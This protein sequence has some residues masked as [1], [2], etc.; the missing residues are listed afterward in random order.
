MSPASSAS[1]TEAIT[2]LLTHVITNKKD[3]VSKQMMKNIKTF[4]GTKRTECIN[5]PQPD[6]SNSQVLQL[7]IYRASLPRYG[8]INATCSL[9]TV[10]NVYRLRNQGCDT[11]KLLRH[12]KHSQSISKTTKHADATKW[13]TGLIQLKIWGNPLSCFLPITKWAVLIAAILFLALS[14]DLSTSLTLLLYSFRILPFISW[15]YSPSP[16]SIPRYL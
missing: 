1:V 6:R 5:W 2:Q 11:S 3:D 13:T 8:P 4:D 14:S 12:T 9:R 7:V 15:C 16:S 10:I